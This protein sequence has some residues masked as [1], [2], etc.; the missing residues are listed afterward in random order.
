M[1]QIQWTSCNPGQIRSPRIDP[2]SEVIYTSGIIQVKH[3]ISAG[4]FVLRTLK[5]SGMPETPCCITHTAPD[6]K[7]RS[8]LYVVLFR[9]GPGSHLSLSL[10]AFINYFYISKTGLTCR[11][12]IK[13]SKSVIFNQSP[14]R[15]L[16]LDHPV[17][18]PFRSDHRARPELTRSLTPFYPGCCAPQIN[19]NSKVHPTLI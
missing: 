9:K 15:G 17:T 13:C 8:Y 11:N 10:E 18:V 7:T 6:T 19:L 16:N 2:M 14:R 5:G 3:Q 1:D 12:L 4:C